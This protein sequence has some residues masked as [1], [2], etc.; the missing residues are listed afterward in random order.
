M[1]RGRRF[2][3][4]LVL[5]LLAAFIG[6]N[7]LAYN[8]A[9]SMM[10]FVPEGARTSKPEALS[11]IQ[12]ARILFTG[13]TVPRPQ[14]AATPSD[15]GMEYESF[16]IASTDGTRLGAWYCENPQRSPLV[17]LFHGYASG[18]AGMLREAAAFRALGC[19]VML[20]DFRGSG[21][22]SETYTTMGMREA[23]DVAAAVNYA[24]A[25]IPYQRIILFGQ[26][27]G[28]AA[29]LGAIHSHGIKPDAVIVEAVFDTMLNTV[30][31]RFRAMGVPS[32]P[33]AELLVF[34]GGRQ[35]GF[36]GFANNPVD[37]ARSVGCPILFLHGSDDPRARIAEARRVFEAVPGEKQF[38]EFGRTGH[39]GYLFRD[40]HGWRAAVEEF[41]AVE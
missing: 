23:D 9:R 13:V 12:K 6:L 5:L 41:L 10:R 16:T 26:S 40:S 25:N 19:S 17:I 36:N 20:V 2:C 34:W 29:V 37:Y 7:I 38:K 30:R 14:S 39:G 24:R 32:F 22:S 4:I 35:M 18:K 28:A 1:A 3:L 11:V 8:N 31:N 33:N 21:E 15:V 27:M